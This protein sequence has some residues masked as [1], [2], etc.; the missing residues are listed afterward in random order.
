MAPKPKTFSLSEALGFARLAAEGAEGIT[1]IVERMHHA[2]L[3]TPGLARLA[4]GLARGIPRLVYRGLGASFRLTAKGAGVASALLDEATQARPP[5]PGREKTL[6]ALNGVL[7]DHLAETGNPLA[8]TMRFRSGGQTLALKSEALSHAFPN[9]T[10]KLVVLV[11]GLCMS[12]LHWRRGSHDH[13]AALARDFGYTPVSLS[14]NTGLHVSTN[15]RAFAAALEE[16]VAAWPVEIEDLLIVGHSMGGLVARSACL[17]GEASAHAWRKKV[18]KL[19]F[20]GTPH[21][22]A[23]LERIGNWAEDILGQIP[24]AGALAPLGK[25]RS[26]GVTD[27]RYGFIADEDWLGRDRFAREPDARRHA[28]LPEDVACYAIAATTASSPGALNDLLIGDGLVPVMSAL[29]RHRDFALDFPPDR[30]WIACE[31]GHFDLLSRPE[32]YKRIAA[33][34]EK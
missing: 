4:P 32:V 17:A 30:Q 15:G 9:V 16:L 1:G 3:D 24:Y 12:D 2:V 14:Y 13:G 25:I 18:S 27:L 33:W 26:A 21:H 5:A 11:H 31:T 34:I 6:A 22:G 10:G 8:L 7:G 20:L 23:P 28:P 19:V 29:G